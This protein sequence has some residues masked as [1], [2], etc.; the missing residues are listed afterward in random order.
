MI[1]KYLSLLFILI[2]VYACATVQSP[3]GG[4]KDEKAPILYESNPKDQSINFKGKEI[5][6]Y[7]NEWMKLEQ[8][9][10]ELIITPREDIKF[11]STLKKQELIIKLNEPLKDSTTYTFNFRKALKDI[12]EGNLW[13]SPII[14]FS[15]GSYLDSLTVEGNVTQL[16]NQEPANSFVVGLY[17]A[18]ADTANLRQGKPVYFTTTNEEGTFKMQNL[19]AGNYLLYA[20]ED[21]ND[22]LINNS[23]SEAFGFH[24]DTLNL[25][26]SLP[27]L[28]ISTYQ[29]NE[30]TLK[31]KKYSPVG[32]DFIIQY[33]KGIANY[34]ITNPQDSSQHIYANDVED[35]KYIKIYKENFPELGYE[36]DSIKLFMEVK[37]S[38]NHSRLDTIYFM[39]RESRITNDDIKITNTPNGKILTG[40]QEFKY[41]FSKPVK[42][43]NYDSIQLRIDTIPIKK[44]T[45]EEIS[46][47]FNRKEINLN[48]IL[49]QT[50]INEIID[51]LKSISDSIQNYK[52]SVQS[53]SD[54]IN[55]RK[56]SI[57]IADKDSLLNQKGIDRKGVQNKKTKNESPE[58]SLPNDSNVSR[59]NSNSNQ[60]ISSYDLKIY[61]GQGSFIGIEEDSTSQNTTKLSFK[62]PEDYGIIK[63]KVINMESDFIIQLISEKYVL[64]D[65]LVNQNEFQFNY[66]EPGNYRIRLIEDE[67]GNGI[68]DA[69]NP[70]TLKPAENIYYLDELITVKANW[71]VID[72]NFDFSVD[73][74]VDEGEETSDL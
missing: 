72:K 12:T 43:I 35:S 53:F 69:G 30:D 56:D 15:T 19:K 58:S 64:K 4:E 42:D 29:R 40:P 50:D 24:P 67:N 36:T 23:E 16:M 27:S 28:S 1:R 48:T 6:L 70:L 26:D 8:L 17:D 51:S 5:K 62:K 61:I 21:K 20:F 66:V 73:N 45:K 31:L 68:W 3:T 37:D 7:F 74:D 10:Q 44:F 25:Y 18:K 11:E 52:D 9:N 39:T 2:I 41:T 34:F 54:S 46:F 49:N 32:K 60:N 55:L 57:D 59:G 38:I 47:S 63:G 14:A 22:N 65:T 13:E 33:N 71:E